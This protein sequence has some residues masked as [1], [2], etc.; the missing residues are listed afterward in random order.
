LSK[1]TRDYD[2]DTKFFL[3]RS[4]PSLREYLLVDSTERLVELFSRHPDNSWR[5]TEYKNLTDSVTIQS[6]GLALQLEH[7]YQGAGL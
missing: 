2:R 1:S 3:Y 4:I 7:I 6:I 5:L